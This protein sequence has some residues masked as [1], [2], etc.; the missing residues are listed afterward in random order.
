MNQITRVICSVSKAN[1]VVHHDFGYTLYLV[2][3][4]HVDEL[5]DFDHI[6]GD[7]FVFDI[8]PSCMPIA[9]ATTL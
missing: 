4:G 8:F 3:L 7:M 5:G 2:T 6:S 9:A 1:T